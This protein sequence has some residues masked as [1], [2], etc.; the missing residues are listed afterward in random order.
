MK[1]LFLL[2]ILYGTVQVWL[3]NFLLLCH[4]LQLVSFRRRKY[5][6]VELKKCFK[7]KQIFSV[8]TSVELF[9]KMAIL[10]NNRKLAA[11]ARETQEYPRNNQSQNSAAPGNT[12]DY[13][14]EV[15]KEIEGRVTKQ[16]KVP[17]LGCTVQV[18]R[19]SLE[20]TNADILRNRSGNIPERRRRKSRTKRGSFSE[21][22]PSSFSIAPA[23]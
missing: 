5:I 2:W 8:F 16:D 18:R 3:Y 13:I 4:W 9:R 20:P 19:F 17:H 23:I 14:A 11:M 10:K 12:E 22:S 1:F 7:K 21:L 6:S 15:S